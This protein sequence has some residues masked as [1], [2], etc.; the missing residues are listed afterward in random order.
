M[1]QLRVRGQV[2]TGLRSEGRH[3]VRRPIHTRWSLLRSSKEYA[4]TYPRAE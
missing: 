3:Y 2:L 1:K 4:K